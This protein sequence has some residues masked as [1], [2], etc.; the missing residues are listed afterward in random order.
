[1][2]DIDAEMDVEGFW[3]HSSL[4]H[5]RV[6][7]LLDLCSEGHLARWWSPTKP[8]RP[9]GRRVFS[10]SNQCW[11]PWIRIRSPRVPGRWWRPGA[12]VAGASRPAGPNMQALCDTAEQRATLML[13]VTQTYD[14]RMLSDH[15]AFSPKKKNSPR[16]AIRYR[17]RI[18]FVDS[19]GI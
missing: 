10:R 19:S 9:S 6:T 16:L 12:G 2:R 14:S 15:R 11:R 17:G 4:R 3:V 13:E 5:G 7:F 18:A 1:M 8:P